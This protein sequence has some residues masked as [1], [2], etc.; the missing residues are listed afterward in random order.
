M[1]IV[2]E[3]DELSPM[4]NA[5]YVPQRGERGGKPKRRAGG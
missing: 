3:K 4:A 1:E 5:E 2:A